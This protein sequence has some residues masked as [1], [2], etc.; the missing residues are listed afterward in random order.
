MQTRPNSTKSSNRKNGRFLKRKR[1]EEGVASTVGT[2]MA[3]LVF[4]TFLTLFTNSYVPVWMIDNERSH[5]SQAMD[6]FGG[7]KG[8]VDDLVVMA[9]VTGRTDLNMYGPV[10]LGANGIP[11]FASPT[12]GQL[13]Y[14]PYGVGNSTVALN[15]TYSLNGKTLGLNDQSGGMLQLYAPNRY[16]VQQWVAYENG[17]IIVKQ[18]DGQV[19]RGMPSLD[20]VKTDTNSRLNVSWT[21]VALIGINSTLAGTSTAGINIDMIYLDSQVYDNGLN[22]MTVYLNFTTLYGKAWFNYLS[23]YFTP[24]LDNHIQ[25]SDYAITHDASYGKISL[26]L[27][28]VSFFNYNK[29]IMQMTVNLA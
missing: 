8:K 26:R 11:V 21:Q 12:A 23:A 15:F 25:S 9:E 10:T 13:I 7:I 4:L 17:A 24:T 29:A 16:Y 27:N 3:L 20:V 28:G 18:L 1:D 6:Q 14:S 5:M 22:P 2:I 19:I